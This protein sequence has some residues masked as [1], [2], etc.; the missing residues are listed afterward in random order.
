MGFVT[1]ISARV[2]GRVKDFCQPG[3]L[4]T[5]Q[6]ARRPYRLAYSRRGLA[7]APTEFPKDRLTKA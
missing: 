3:G 5:S 7:R 6:R 4:S 1:Q 2:S